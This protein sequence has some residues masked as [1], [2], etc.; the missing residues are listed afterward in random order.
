MTT[1]LTS[2]ELVDELSNVVDPSLAQKVMESYG[3]IQQRFLAGDW[4]PAELNGGRLCE[5]VSRCLYQIDTGKVV[6]SKGVG[7]IRKY[8][9]DNSLPHAMA[10][11]D[12]YH[13]VKVMEVVYKFRNERGA[14]HISPDYDANYMD[15][16]LVLHA[17]KWVL[18]EFLRLAWRKDERVIASTIAQ[19]VQLEHSVIHELDGKPLVLA[20]G[21]SA[22]HEVLLLLNHAPDHRLSRLELQ[23][24][25]ANQRP[26]NVAVAIA[27][28][29]EKKDI[30]PVGEEVALT[31]N[32]QER[33]M[34]EI[35]P[36]LATAKAARRAAA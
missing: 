1:K 36:K 12:R 19:L 9:L 30:R 22:T 21:I 4:Q 6:H 7:E 35:L 23:R 27:R 31:P 2:K 18:A 11:K 14:V 25:A 26:Q 29:I 34:T 17:A 24:Q 33:V 10:G 3:E 13:I 20:R 28:L 15:S 8:L 5:A 16:M 32:G